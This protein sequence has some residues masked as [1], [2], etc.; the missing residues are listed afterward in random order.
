ML[1]TG[2]WLPACP[3]PQDACGHETHLAGKRTPSLLFELKP[4]PYSVPTMPLKVCS[5][6]PVPQVYQHAPEYHLTRGFN[7]V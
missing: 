4:P 2:T 7:S 6:F 5:G 1:N 3:T